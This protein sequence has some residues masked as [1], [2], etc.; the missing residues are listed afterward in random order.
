VPGD[1]TAPVRPEWK[2]PLYFALAWSVFWTWIVT[3]GGMDS[4]FFI[5]IFVIVPILVVSILLIVWI[6]GTTT[7]KGYR[8]SLP[9]LASLAV[10]LSIPMFLYLYERRH[11]VAIRE[12]AKWIVS[13]DKYKAEVQA[14]KASP[15]GELRHIDW[16]F[17]GPSFAS[18]TV[19]LVFDPSDSLVTA[20]KNHQPGKFG[21]LPCK[22]YEVRRLESHWYAVV[23]YQG[24]DWD[25]CT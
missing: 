14:E 13:S 15:N 12:T 21:G 9:T 19:Y 11:P 25:E 10:L 20:A 8:Q 4:F 1:M 6:V 2:F 24:Q 16:D 5:S 3:S 17:S 22:V 23:F 7:T 18:T